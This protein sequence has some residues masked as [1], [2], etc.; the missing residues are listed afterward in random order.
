MVFSLRAVRF[1]LKKYVNI[2]PVL[3]NGHLQKSPPKSERGE[4]QKSQRGERP[5]LKGQ[6]YPQGVNAHIP[7]IPKN[8]RPLI[9]YLR[10]AKQTVMRQAT[11]KRGEAQAVRQAVNAT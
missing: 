5:P 8:R 4:C 6:V 9:R 7:R 1:R 10:E 3:L 11:P 2:K